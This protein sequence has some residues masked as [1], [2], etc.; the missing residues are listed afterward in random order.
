MKTL[1]L[2]LTK[3]LNVLREKHNK[4]SKQ[5]MKEQMLP[6]A[7]PS[8]QS[9]V[10]SVHTTLQTTRMALLATSGFA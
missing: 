4:T 1:F 7:F 8:L 2:I 9:R 10:H 6:V 3:R 5:N